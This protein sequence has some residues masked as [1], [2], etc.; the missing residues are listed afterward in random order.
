MNDLHFVWMLLAN[1]AY[2]LYGVPQIWEQY[3][4]AEASFWTVRPHLRFPS[5]T[6][7]L[8]LLRPHLSPVH[9]VFIPA[10]ESFLFINVA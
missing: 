8:I 1:V 3:K 7:P 2:L 9:I 4:K 5:S 6:S 10:H